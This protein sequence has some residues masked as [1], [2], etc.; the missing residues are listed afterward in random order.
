MLMVPS[1]DIGRRVPMPRLSDIELCAWI[2]QAEP[3][4]F[5]EY[6]R[7]FLG[8]DVTPVISLLPEPERHRLA[9]AA[10]A[11]HR[12]FEAGLVHLV[13]VRLGPEQFVYLAIAR[14]RPRAAPGSP[15]ALL[16]ATPVA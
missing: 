6:H 7:G 12:A 2:A 15:S 10:R 13:Q 4:D 8:I 16:L 5:L 1:T 3:G 11:A 14:P 9:A